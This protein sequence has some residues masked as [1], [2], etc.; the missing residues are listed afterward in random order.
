MSNE[1]KVVTLSYEEH[2][3]LL[4]IEKESIKRTAT[5]QLTIHVG[6]FSGKKNYGLYTEI[7]AEIPED[8]KNY[9][10]STFIDEIQSSISNLSDLIKAE[11]EAKGYLDELIRIKRHSFFGWVCEYFKK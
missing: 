3:R 11:K 2:E 1:K 8:I 10:K 5:I 6:S 9:F 4:E 7:G